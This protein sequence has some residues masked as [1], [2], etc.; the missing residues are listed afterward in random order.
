MKKKSER[1][2]DL[3]HRKNHFESQILALFDKAVKLGKL[4]GDGYIC[5]YVRLFEW[6]GSPKMLLSTL[7]TLVLT[8]YMYSEE[9][10]I[11]HYDYTN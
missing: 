3:W 6:D 2:D 4:Y 8:Q 9:I 1:F 11:F 5:K 7:M 10:F